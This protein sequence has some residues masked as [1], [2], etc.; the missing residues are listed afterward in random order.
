MQ[1]PW[2]NVPYWLAS[3]GLLSLLSY[4]TKTTSPEMVP[5]TR[6]FP[7]WSPIE[8]MPYSWISWRY[9][10]NWSSFL[11]DNSSCVKLTHKTTQYTMS[12]HNSLSQVH[13]PVSLQLLHTH[14]HTHTHTYVLLSPC[15][16][17]GVDMWLWMTTSYWMTYQWAQ[18]WRRLI[19]PLS[20]AIDGL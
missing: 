3:P 14:T 13:D 7:P 5:P 2:R 12:P 4:R 19:L 6:A 8:K 20:A 16:V 15:R 1:K 10:L 18:P 9:F 11:C 17:A